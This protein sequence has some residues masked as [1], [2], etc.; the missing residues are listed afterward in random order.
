MPC[1]EKF[2]G[3]LIHLIKTSKYV[4]VGTCSKDSVPSVSLMNYSYIPRDKTFDQENDKNDYII[5]ATNKDSEKYH[6]MVANPP[7]SLLF[8]DWITANNLSVRKASLSQT[9]TPDP[10]STQLNPASGTGGGAIPNSHPSKL[11]NLLHE[12]NQAELNQMSANIKGHAKIVDPATEESKF[13]KQLLLKTNPDAE[14]FILGDNTVIVKVKIESAKV[15][16]SENNTA[17]YK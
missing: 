5:F 9:P 4:H 11:L 13:Y 2:P 8:H 16:D 1:T 10:A 3:H 6:N 12:L 17:V 14:V 15:T 7:V